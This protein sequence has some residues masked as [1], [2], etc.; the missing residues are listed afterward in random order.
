MEI[1]IRDVLAKSG[2]FLRQHPIYTQAMRLPVSEQYC[3][4]VILDPN[5]GVMYHEKQGF[6]RYVS[7]ELHAFHLKQMT[8]V[9]HQPK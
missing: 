9:C 7:K 4:I 2:R 6:K 1:D 8:C 5:G 3:I